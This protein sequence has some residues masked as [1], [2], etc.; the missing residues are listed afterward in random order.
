MDNEPDPEQGKDGGDRNR[1]D[2][3]DHHSNQQREQAEDQRPPPVGPLESDPNLAR[4]VCVC[5]FG[6]GG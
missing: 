1:Q 3:V 6:G 2:T 4:R 5:V